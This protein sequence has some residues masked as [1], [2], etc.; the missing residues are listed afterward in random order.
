MLG[1]ILTLSGPKSK[2]AG[3]SPMFELPADEAPANKTVNIRHR[4]KKLNMEKALR[5]LIGI[6]DFIFT[7][8]TGGQ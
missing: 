8:R 1:E 4:I 5:V 3:M 2:V 6:T 7:L